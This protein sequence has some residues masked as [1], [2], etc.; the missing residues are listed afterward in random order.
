M[1][2]TGT[3]GLGITETEVEETSA[4]ARTGDGR[5]GE[6][7]AEVK[8]TLQILRPLCHDRELRTRTEGRTKRPV[9]QQ[10]SVPELRTI[11]QSASEIGTLEGNCGRF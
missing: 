11:A 1:S 3:I 4:E 7:T 8:A 9:T 6:A 2:P 10:Q 5:T